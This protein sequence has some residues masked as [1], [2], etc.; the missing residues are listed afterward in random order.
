M[1]V[2][3][4]IGRLGI[5]TLVRLTPEHLIKQDSIAWRNVKLAIDEREKIIIGGLL[6]RGLI[7]RDSSS[8]VHSAPLGWSSVV[9]D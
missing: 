4:V 1:Q 2:S 8:V 6:L 5:Q 7:S 9:V 3:V